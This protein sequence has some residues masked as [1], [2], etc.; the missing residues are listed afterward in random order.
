M[1][2]EEYRLEDI[3]TKTDEATAVI[4]KLLFRG[5]YPNII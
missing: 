1:I 5:Y 3:L 2:V 4:P